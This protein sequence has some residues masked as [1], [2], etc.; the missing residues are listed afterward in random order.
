ML[1]SERQKQNAKAKSFLFL[2]LL[3]GLLPECVL[4][5]RVDLFAS[6]NL[7]RK[8]LQSHVQQFGYLLIS[9][10]AS[11]QPRPQEVTYDSRPNA[12]R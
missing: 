4:Y 8:I 10:L 7:I 11:R 12:G 2:V 3:C 9:V 6:I 1:A 5:I